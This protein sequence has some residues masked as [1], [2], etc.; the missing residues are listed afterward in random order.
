MTK[1][2]TRQSYTLDDVVTAL[3]AGRERSAL[4]ALRAMFE[5][6]SDA[7]QHLLMTCAHLLR[8]S[9]PTSGDTVV[10]VRAIQSE[11]DKLSDDERRMFTACV[12]STETRADLVTDPT[13]LAALLRQDPKPLRK[14]CKS[15]RWLTARTEGHERDAVKICETLLRNPSATDPLI[16]DAIHQSRA[17]W[18]RLN[19]PFRALVMS[20]V[21]ASRQRAELANQRRAARAQKVEAETGDIHRCGNCDGNLSMAPDMP[22]CSSTCRHEAEAFEGPAP[23]DYP[24]PGAANRAAPRHEPAEKRALSPIV[25]G[26]IETEYDEHYREIIRDIPLIGRVRKDDSVADRYDDENLGMT[27]DEETWDEALRRDE[28]E[29]RARARRPLASPDALCISC[30]LERTPAE[31]RTEPIGQCDMCAEVD[32]PPL[33]P[34]WHSELIAA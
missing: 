16:V 21:Y 4:R 19:A 25:R 8:A 2:V 5:H 33:K 3:Q 12:Y 22:F 24:K 7:P 29:V 1:S 26:P 13:E 31:H 23:T 11:L 32:A 17:L 20:C 18:P 6:Q 14:A 34:E 15:L 28:R 10:R 30:N 27:Y 9:D